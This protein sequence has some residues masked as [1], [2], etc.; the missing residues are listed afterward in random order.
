MQGREGHTSRRRLV[1]A[2]GGPL[3]ALVALAALAPSGALAAG[4]ISLGTTSLSFEAGDGDVNNLAV[5][6]NLGSVTVA[7][8]TPGAQIFTGEGDCVGGGSSSVT[9]T[10]TGLIFVSIDLGDENDTLLGTG[11]L[12]LLV[13]GGEGNDQITTS[14]T[15]TR[16][17]GI[18]GED[19]DDILN[20]GD[21]VSLLTAAGGGQS[22]VGDRV[23]GQE[24]NDLM[25]TGNGDDDAQGGAGADTIN[26]GSG[27]DAVR[28][29]DG[30][31]DTVDAGPGNDSV[32][33]T[34]DQAVGD[35]YRGGTGTDQLTLTISG[36][37]PEPGVVLPAFNVDLAAGTIGVTAPPGSLQATDFEDFRSDIGDDAVLGSSGPNRIVVGGGADSVTPRE[38]SDFVELQDGNDS[39]DTRDGY[40]DRV[41]CAQGTDSLQADQ[42]DVLSDCENVTI[43]R[44][45]PAGA[46]RIA[47]R[48]SLTRVKK[49]YRRRAFLRG[50]VARARCNEPATLALRLVAAVKSSNGA[51]RPAK[52]GDLVLAE[53]TVRVGTRARRVRLR[54]ARR[55][56]RALNGRFRARVVLEARDEFGNRSRRSRKLS[57]RG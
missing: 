42:L 40:A 44:M 18:D 32:D 26:T 3:L 37:N 30:N 21:F 17:D 20:T 33:T 27:N 28:P 54:P 48:C 35:V 16:G 11:T 47:P 10:R 55:L 12:G 14:S 45:R 13:G 50:V 22:F 53:R 34:Q 57:V 43:T 24:G 15:N 38:G 1:K 6:A 52:N 8:N 36:P 39:G 23:F 19:G 29:D 4:S 49:R 41:L 56:R 51:L 25:T 2:L 9:C 46:D 31:G 5:T 7:D